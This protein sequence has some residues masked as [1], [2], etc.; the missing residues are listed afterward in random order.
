MH[1]HLF[2]KL[3]DFYELVNYQLSQSRYKYIL[4]KPLICLLVRRRSKGED[5]LAWTDNLEANNQNAI[6]IFRI[7]FSIK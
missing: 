3:A 4:Y 6:Q 2:Y 5:T 7:S 1:S